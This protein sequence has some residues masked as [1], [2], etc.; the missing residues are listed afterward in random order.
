MNK[1]I[2]VTG[3]LGFIGSH[4]VQE[5]LRDP[6]CVVTVVDDL[7]GT[8]LDSASITDQ[9]TFERPGQLIV[10]CESV[11]DFERTSADPLDRLFFDRP[12]TLSLRGAATETGPAGPY[13]TIYHLASI[14]GP[15][16]VLKKA[17]RIAESIIRDSYVAIRLAQRYGARL[18]NISTSEVYGG[19]VN[20]LCR[21]DTPRVIRGAASARQEYAAGKLAAEV[22]IENL[23]RGGQL[24]A[25]T[26]RP[27]NVAGI[28][29]AGRGGFVLPRFIGQAI[30]ERP[31][32]V[33][34]EGRQVRAFTDVRDVVSGVLLCAQRGKSGRAYNVG[35]PGNRISIGELASHVIAV[36]G[37]R[38]EIVHLDP[39]ELYGSAYAEAADKFPDAGELMGMG[40]RAAFSLDETIRD[41]YLAMRDLPERELL[42]LSGLPASESIPEPVPA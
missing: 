27:F 37:S 17:G 5:L 31:L 40:W 1:R 20:G 10:H 38:S 39:Q 19:G 2:L 23:C 26:I 13:D 16:A 4:L 7:S 42:A 21:E 18:V 6:D 25:V 32:T 8:V 15:A 24:D 36:T 14:V 33:F 9:I 11:E 3:G 41:T 22:A 35:N 28:R 34:G 12:T 30:L 29:Q